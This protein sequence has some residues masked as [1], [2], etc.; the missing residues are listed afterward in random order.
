[1]DTALVYNLRYRTCTDIAK[2]PE[3]IQSPAVCVYNRQVYATGYKNVYRYEDRDVQDG[4][5]IAL[6]THIRLS[7]MVSYKG[8]I[9]CVQSYFNDL[10]RFK[11]F[12]DTRLQ[13]ITTFDIP[14]S[15]MC[16]FGECITFTNLIIGIDKYILKMV[17]IILV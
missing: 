16:L 1:M 10:Y 6:E 5:V 11:P 15:T 12:V 8:Y 14:P 17:H 9:Y 13:Q 2:F 4:W 3:A 7:C